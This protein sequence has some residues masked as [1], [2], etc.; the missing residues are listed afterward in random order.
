MHAF[1]LAA[2]HQAD[3]SGGA[4][5]E[6]IISIV[7]GLGVIPLSLL[8]R[9]ISRAVFGINVPSE[10]DDKVD[11]DIGYGAV[12]DVPVE[13]RCSDGED[14]VVSSALASSGKEDGGKAVV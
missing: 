9:V 12:V 6:W 4:G 2:L 10:G 5:T 1:A 11:M 8:T 13:T 14:P 7:I 3:P